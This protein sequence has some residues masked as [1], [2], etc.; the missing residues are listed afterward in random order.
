[1]SYFARHI[2]PVS[3][4]PSSFAPSLD[5]SANDEVYSRMIEGEQKQDP[6]RNGLAVI[7]DVES[8]RGFGPDGPFELNWG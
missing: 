1:M 2:A 6:E 5:S 3:A 7:I 4:K 8:V